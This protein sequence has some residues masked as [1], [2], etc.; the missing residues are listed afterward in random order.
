MVSEI[1][2]R[3]L[4]VDWFDNG[5]FSF[6]QS[7][8]EELIKNLEKSKTNTTA[9]VKSKLNPVFSSL[10]QNGRLLTSFGVSDFTLKINE[11][12]KKNIFSNITQTLKETNDIVNSCEF[13]AK[14][15]F[16]SGHGS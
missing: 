11:D 5:S 16:V 2:F 13:G 6:F 14:W 4:R 10:T 3:D 8:L 9:F 7:Y 15:S 1:E 12:I